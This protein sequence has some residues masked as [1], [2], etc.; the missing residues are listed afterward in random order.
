MRQRYV[1]S[2][3][4]LCLVVV[5]GS[6]VGCSNAGN[7]ESSTGAAA[8]PAS[9]AE[10]MLT[11]AM[12]SAA[13]QKATSWHMTM[14]SKASD[15]SMDIS[16]PDKMRMQTKAGGQMIETVRV[17]NDMFTKMGGKWMKVP[18]TMKQQP[19]CG[20]TA[21]ANSRVGTLDPTATY[22]KKGTDT[23][24]G[25][26]CN[27]WEISSKDDKGAVHTSTVCVGSDNLPRQM[28]VADSV[29]TYSDWNKPVTIE[30]PKM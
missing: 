20:S 26:S 27:V 18:S 15:M 13:M 23:V 24:N 12:M 8:A 17:G 11:G 28:K 7:T 22:A 4:G 21:D 29:M 9:K 25:E 3:L 14:K 1:W 19:V 5:L 2:V 30:A 10:V 6:V 16:C